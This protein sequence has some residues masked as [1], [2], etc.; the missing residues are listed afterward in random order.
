MLYDT[1]TD[2]ITT[3]MRMSHIYQPVM[4]LLICFAHGGSRLRLHSSLRP[5]SHR[6][7]TIVR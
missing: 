5:N 2:F 4:L 7:V 3:K 1:L 6:P